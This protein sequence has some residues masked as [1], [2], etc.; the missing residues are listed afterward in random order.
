MAV[1]CRHLLLQ[2]P[3]MHLDDPWIQ[4]ATHLAASKRIRIQ[5]LSLP[6]RIW[7][8]DFT[9][10]PTPTEE[11][12][13]S[14]SS[15]PCGPRVLRYSLLHATA[16]VGM[17]L[18]K[19]VLA[20]TPAPTPVSAA[21]AVAAATDRTWQS[22]RGLAGVDVCRHHVGA[23]RPM[24]ILDSGRSYVLAASPAREDW[25]RQ[26]G[27]GGGARPRGAGGRSVGVADSHVSE[28][29]QAGGVIIKKKTG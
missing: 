27:R 18:I 8:L 29:T 23:G 19:G 25:V 15:S 4:Q 11:K 28:G 6:P 17:P 21:A 24:R 1:G 7:D 10:G 16:E 9:P 26:V 2:L 22:L 12:G 5:L 13:G 20:L 3:G 14:S